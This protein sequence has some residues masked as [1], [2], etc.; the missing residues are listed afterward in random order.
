MYF[1]IITIFCSVKH[2]AFWHHSRLSLKGSFASETQSTEDT[3]VDQIFYAL[4]G[5]VIVPLLLPNNC[6]LTVFCV[7]FSLRFEF[8]QMSVV[9]ALFI[10]SV[11]YT[12]ASF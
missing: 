1:V 4:L 7:V 6:E 8:H 9:V 10:P 5:S 2:N 3:R 12:L 11:S